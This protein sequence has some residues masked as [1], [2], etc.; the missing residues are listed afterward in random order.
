MNVLNNHKMRNPSVVISSLHC[1]TSF[2]CLIQGYPV[3]S[4]GMRF[5]IRVCYCCLHSAGF[6]CVSFAGFFP[7]RRGAGS[8]SSLSSVEHSSSSWLYIKRERVKYIMVKS[9]LRYFACITKKV[10]GIYIAC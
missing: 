4:G 6:S 2:R 8:S 3:Y 7:R 9:K 5:N 10:Y 1:T